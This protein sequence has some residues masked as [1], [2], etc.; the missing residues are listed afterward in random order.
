[1]AGGATCGIV[2]G[3]IMPGCIPDDIAAFGPNSSY[4]SKQLQYS[5]CVTVNL[6]TKVTKQLHPSL[7]STAHI[8]L[9]DRSKQVVVVW[10]RWCSW[11]SPFAIFGQ[12]FAD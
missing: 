5:K 4:T 7:P 2:E 12:H 1:V 8:L 11:V 9:P 6:S 10:Y 3:D